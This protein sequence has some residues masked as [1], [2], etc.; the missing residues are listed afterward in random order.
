VCLRATLILRADPQG[1][2]T[3][4]LAFQQLTTC[5][6]FAASAEL[7]KPVSDLFAQRSTQKAFATVF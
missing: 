5:D 1:G 3:A 6:Q 2:S 4:P 7:L